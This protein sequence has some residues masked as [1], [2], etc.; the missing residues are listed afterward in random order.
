[1][2][3]TLLLI[4]LCLFTFLTGQTS[5]DVLTLVPQKSEP[6][7]NSFLNYALNPLRI[8]DTQA[9]PLHLD[10][11]HAE[12]EKFEPGEGFT[13]FLL[14]D[15]L[16]ELDKRTPFIV[17]HNAT[18]E[19]YIRVFLR[20]QKD[21]ISEVL[22]RSKYY[23]PI[24]EKYLDQYDLP[25][26]IKY[27]AIVESGLDPGAVSTS[28]AKGLWQFMYGTAV[29][30]NLKINSYVDERLDYLKSTEAACIYLKSLHETF[31]DW[32]LALA[33]Y[34][35]GPANVKKAIIRSGGKTNYWEIRHYLPVETRGYL[36]AFYATM[37][38]HQ[39]SQFH[40]LWPVQDQIKLVETDTIHLK[41]NLSL[42]RT[43]EAL[44]VDYGVLKRL[45]PQYKVDLIP[46]SEKNASYLTLLSNQIDKFLENES[47]IYS[48]SGQQ[49]TL[50][51]TEN[52]ISINKTNSYLVKKGD[53][54]QAIARQ[55]QTSVE[56]LMIWNG[57]ETNF[58]IEGQRLVIKNGNKTPE[59]HRIALKSES[60]T[61][62]P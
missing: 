23:F 62:S 40:N 12:N 2:K 1:M 7:N 39:F 35:C 54:L 61:E 57:L 4:T 58:L 11:T 16:A 55:H 53:H 46:K 21:R 45:N 38:L 44:G 42:E 25:L 31:H 49:Q 32:D 36:P 33:A 5:R 28:G 14:A 43:S 13:S 37:Y 26:E 50:K 15:Q 27:L 10:W 29:D 34:N 19:R 17:S 60:L 22:G 18:L 41:G 59:N 8:I 51:S 6:L 47:E 3:K 56:Q 9:K 52:R 24:I 48:V 30:H 20:D